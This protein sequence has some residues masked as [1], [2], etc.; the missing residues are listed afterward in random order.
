MNLL[1]WISVIMLT[2]GA[3]ASALVT[4]AQESTDSTMTVHVVQRGENLFRIALKY[5][6]FA[7]DLAAANGITDSDSI[8]VGQR[9][10]IPLAGAAEAGAETGTALTESEPKPIPTSAP[11]PAIRHS[12]SRFGEP[13]GNF[14][15]TVKSGETLSAIGLRYNQT[16]DALATANRLRDP[17]F[18]S[19]GQ[20]LIVP[21]IQLPRLT[22][23]L[24]EIVTAFSIDPLVFEAGRSG[25]IELITSE[26]V[27]VGGQFLGRDLRVIERGNGLRHSVLIGVPMF[28][29]KN[30]YPLSFDLK[31]E[32]DQHFTVAATVQ[33]MSGG[34]GRQT[35]T[36][37]DNDLLAPAVEEEEIALLTGH[38]ERFTPLRYWAQSLSLPA[39]AP[40]NAVFGTLR[41]YNGSPFDRYHGGVDFA[42]APGTAVLA[43]ADGKVVLV[44]RLHIRGN[45]TLIDHGWGLYTLYAHQ[46]ET[47]VELG[48]DV[49][50]GQMIGT[51][52][53]TGR[54]T[55]P[56]LHWEAWL[57]GV[58]IDPMQWVQESFS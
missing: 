58:N 34:Y 7:E 54:S 45:T 49:T 13:S 23:E 46:D 33:V 40:I 50:S 22:L 38:T 24:P 21:G 20:R 55:G 42:G 32:R 12:F 57:N 27:A 44:D 28:T 9:L 47:F 56:H 19:I 26:R 15:H 10:I 4:W 29:E 39:A 5:D 43:A 48:M 11:R 18:L 3:L 25:Q 53:S 1:H 17:G 2:L 35:L 31:D 36:I 6:L 16:I 8:A 51:V 41:S 37:D 14:T 30:V 52:G